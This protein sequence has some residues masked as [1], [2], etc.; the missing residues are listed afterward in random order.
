MIQTSLTLDSGNLST[1]FKHLD[2]DKLF[3]QFGVGFM[4][5]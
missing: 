3:L 5:F 1:L 4:I 2:P